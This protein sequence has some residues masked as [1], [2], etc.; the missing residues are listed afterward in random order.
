LRIDVSGFEPD[1]ELSDM[2]LD[3]RPFYLEVRVMDMNVGGGIFASFIVESG[4]RASPP[5]LRRP[6]RRHGD[7]APGSRCKYGAAGLD[8]GGYQDLLD[9]STSVGDVADERHVLRIA[10]CEER[11]KSEGR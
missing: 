11:L 4:S 1:Y 2:L 3:R 6:R 7:E 10:R 9:A 5:L 8:K